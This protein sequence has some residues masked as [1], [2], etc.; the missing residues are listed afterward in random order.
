ML[1]PPLFIPP[2]GSHPPRRMTWRDTP[3]S[4]IV[5]SLVVSTM[6]LSILVRT[7]CMLSRSLHNSHLATVQFTSRLPS[8]FSATSRAL[9]MLVSFSASI[10]CLLVNSLVS[11]M[12]TMPTTSTHGVPLPAMSSQ[13][14]DLLSA[15]RAV[16]NGV[17][18]FRPQK[19]NTWQWE[20]V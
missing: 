11:P 5:R 20:T 15:G 8:I 19:R 9:L 13:S 3:S 17:L 14:V 6:L 1:W 10:R 2:F 4:H 7:S 12:L 18:P 16:A